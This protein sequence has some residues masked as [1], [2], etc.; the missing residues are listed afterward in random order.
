LSTKFRA[1]HVSDSEGLPAN[2]PYQSGIR[3]FLRRT[4]WA[5][6]RIYAL[7]VLVVYLLQGRLLYLSTTESLANT[8]D[9]AKAEQLAIWPN[10]QHYLG[11][12]STPSDSVATGTA[13]LFHG[14]AGVAADRSFYASRFARCGLRTILVEYPGYG[15]RPVGELSESALSAEGAEIILAARAEFGAPV[16]VVGESLGAAVAAQAIQRAEQR[17]PNSVQAA[18]LITPWDELA[19]PAHARFWFLPV[20]L[21]LRDA[22]NSVGALKDFRA[23]LV[24]LRAQSDEIIPE[25]ATLRLF[26]QYPGPKTL[27]ELPGGHNSLWEDADDAWWQALCARLQSS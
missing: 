12:V 5:C 22:Y 4:F 7:V 14:N 27:L 13:V 3:I 19:S 20:R 6:V 2:R 17:I 11:L 9:R 8:I 25:A 26:E 23:P 18:L 15:A 24:V 21:I 10:A 1:K 16:H